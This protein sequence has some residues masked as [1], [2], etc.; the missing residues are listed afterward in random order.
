MN[1]VALSLSKL[2]LDRQTHDDGAGELESLRYK[3]N[4]TKLD[5]SN[6]KSV[7]VSYCYQ[8]E[9]G[10]CKLTLCCDERYGRL[11]CEHHVRQLLQAC[12]QR[13]S[14]DRGR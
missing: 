3:I 6:A 12:L 11:Q 4:G 7:K 5:I 10:T 9:A 8:T 13:N 2:D 14:R 1:A